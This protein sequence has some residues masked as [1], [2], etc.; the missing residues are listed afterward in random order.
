MLSVALIILGNS[1]S[2]AD[3]DVLHILQYHHIDTQT[4][5]STST[6]P[7]LFEKHLIYLE[8]EGYT[9]VRLSEAIN[10]LR[11][12]GTL[13]DKAVALTFDDGFLSVYK[14]AFPII[15]PH[16]FP[17]TVFINPDALD[18]GSTEHMT[19]QQ[20]KELVSGG[21]E[22]GNHSIGHIHMIEKGADESAEAWKR[23]ISD[24][25]QKAENRIQE[26]LGQ[27]LK[28]LAY[29][30]GE[31]D[32]ELV[33]LVRTLGFVGLGQQSGPVG[34]ESDWQ[35]VP[36]FPLPNDYG[37]MASLREKLKTL[38]LYPKEINPESIIIH[39]QNPPVLEFRPTKASP[40][41]ISCYGSG[42]GKIETTVDGNRVTVS[43][44]AAFQSRRF[45]YNCT[46][47]AGSGH[48]YW[49]SF[50]WINPEISD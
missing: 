4:P 31:F 20:A 8:T 47:P 21:A 37:D 49:H 38:P 26:Q 48:F 34:T 9:V 43:G 10:T 5:R 45:R 33:Q 42:Q 36:R 46:A 23:R 50:P 1:D 19:W 7:L 13:P 39:E 22:F 30:Y 35:T 32:L 18:I 29:P 24:N 15:K 2:R 44:N 6:S 41:S 3:S 27:S 17:F 12:G 14:N 40:G 11:Q 28:M 25:I 16:G